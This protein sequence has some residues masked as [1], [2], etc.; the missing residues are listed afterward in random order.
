MNC[1][2]ERLGDLCFR[3]GMLLHTERFC[4]KKFQHSG[5]ME[6]EWGGLL[7]A[8]PHMV[9]GKSKWLREEGDNDWGD[10][11]G[12]DSRNQNFAKDQGHK[13]K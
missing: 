3:C 10:W 9:A 13:L 2:Y 11:Y 6:K 8:Q 1:K 5:E 7:R 4:Q 12:T